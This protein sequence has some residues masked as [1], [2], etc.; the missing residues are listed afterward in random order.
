MEGLNLKV[1]LKLLLGALDYSSIYERCNAAILEPANIFKQQAQMFTMKE[2]I[3]MIGKNE[4]W[5]LVD[6][7]KNKVIGVKQVYRTKFDSYG[8]VNKLKA[9]FVVK[10]YSQQYRVNFTDTFAP[11][12]RYD[13]I[14]IAELIIIYYKWDLT[15]VLAK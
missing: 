6:K 10:G 4:T 1:I 5:Q 12:A 13:N 11:G 15:E 8:S 3:S 7:P 9:R 2:E 14:S